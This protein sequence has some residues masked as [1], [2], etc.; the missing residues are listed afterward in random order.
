MTAAMNHSIIQYNLLLSTQNNPQ[1]PLPTCYLLLAQNMESYLFIYKTNEQ[2][3]IKL[4]TGSLHQNCDAYLALIHLQ[5]TWSWNLHYQA[6][7]I[8]LII[9]ETSTQHEMQVSLQV[10]ILAAVRTQN[11]I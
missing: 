3:L 4:D 9:Q 5:F 1:L 11:L 8:W 7:K 10:S 6:S 2:I